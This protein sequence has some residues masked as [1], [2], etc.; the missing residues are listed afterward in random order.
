VIARFSSPIKGIQ[1]EDQS[2]TS[3]GL[4]YLYLNATY[5]R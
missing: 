4:S 2:Q 1:P 3:I 5:F